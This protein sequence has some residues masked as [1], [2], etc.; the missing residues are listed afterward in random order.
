MTIPL[1]QYWTLL[2]A[3]LQP[4]WLRVLL[5]VFLLFSAIGLQLLVPQMLRQFIDQSEAGAELRKLTTTA[6]LF[7]GIAIG[8]QVFTVASAYVSEQVGW[9][10]TNELR[11][12]LARHCLALDMPFHNEHTPGELI[13]R[14]DGDVASLA[15]FF[16]QIVLSMLGSLVLLGGVLIILFVEVWWVGIVMTIYAIITLTALARMRNIAVPFWKKSRE[17]AADLFGFLEE[18]LAGT[19][20]IRANGAVPYTL[21]QLYQNTRNRLEQELRASVVNIRLR[22]LHV[23]LHLAGLLLTVI[24]GYLLHQAG[25]ISVGTVFL[26]VYY[27]NTLFEPLR[28]IT[29]QMEEL[30]Q[31]SASIQWVD[32][33][34]STQPK[35][36]NPSDKSEDRPSPLD[37]LASDE[38]AVE[39]DQVSFGYA[40]ENLVLKKVSFRVEAGKVLGIL[41][42]TGSG[43]TTIARLLFRLYDPSVGTIRVGNRNLRSLQL[44]EL[45]RCIG[46]VTQSVQLFRGTV[47][48]NLTFFDRTISDERIQDVLVSIGLSKWLDDLSNGLDTW[49]KSD[50]EGLSAGEAQ[51]LTFARVFLKE[52]GLVILDEASSR[53]DPATEEQIEN[54]V[55]KLLEGRTGIIIAHRLTTIQRADQILILDDGEVVEHGDRLDLA[56]I[57]DSRFAQLLQT[58]LTE[59]PR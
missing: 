26:F 38:L 58:G 23:G 37:G 52:P 55:D 54:A 16:S 9:R 33:L 12:K 30:Q 22:Y 6:L 44:S 53:L 21:R 48:D 20:D 4:Q 25:T 39:L 17:A 14:I 47:R 41:G 28:Q 7:I 43:K 59:V 42:R 3:Y 57:P 35:I 18:C 56:D 46:M 50:G 40:T 15:S 13:E 19:V 31:A 5:L 2:A 29:N 36:L 32:E 8:Q 27:T 45:R 49:L 1:K 10:A 24:F 11:A 51:L 34:F